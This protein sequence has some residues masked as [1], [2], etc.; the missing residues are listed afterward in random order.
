MTSLLDAAPE[1]TRAASY[2]AIVGT[3]AAHGLAVLVASYVG[4]RGVSELQRLLPVTEM[5]EVELP[6]APKTVADAT[7]T[8]T[9]PPAKARVAS[10][11][12]A[13]PPPTAAQ[14]GQVLDAKSDV[15]DFDDSVV[16]GAGDAYA[17]GV[18]DKS[19]TSTSAV[20]DVQAQ[21]HGGGEAK[22]PPAPA[23]DLSRPPRLDGSA[24][25]QCPFP[26]EA[27]DAGIDHA[28]VTLRVEIAANGG[29]RNVTTVRDPGN[30]FGREARRCASSKRWLVGFDRS[31]RAIAASATVNVR[32]ER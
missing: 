24:Q 5:V 29:V 25:W 3:I 1:T 4:V 13:T 20:R 27:D 23:P 18:T 2:V 21:G 16:T 6:E 22:A 8:A 17:G 9:P 32:F 19:G 10:P 28:V 31:G 15:V 12:P 11:T 30:G 26:A 14:A 7:P